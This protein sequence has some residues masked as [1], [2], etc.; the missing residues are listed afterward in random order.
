MA[1][2]QRQRHHLQHTLWERAQRRQAV[3][4][5]TPHAAGFCE[6]VLRDL[7]ASKGRA[8]RAQSRP[9]MP[10]LG[11]SVVHEVWFVMEVH[12]GR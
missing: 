10:L 7:Q 5:S 9:G 4:S 1:V 2:R 11:T 8:S 3:R 12:G 6:L